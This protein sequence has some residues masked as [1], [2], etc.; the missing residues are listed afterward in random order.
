MDMLL[1]AAA[2][3]LKLPE[4]SVRFDLRRKMFSEGILDFVGDPLR[5][6]DASEPV[7]V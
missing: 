7:D 1:N 4:F 6:E 3:L 5:E 2:V